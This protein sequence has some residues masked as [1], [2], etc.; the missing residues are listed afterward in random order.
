M[1]ICAGE[2][3]VDLFIADA[4]ETSSVPCFA[5][6]GGSPFNC[7]RAMARLGADVGFLGQLSQDAFGQLLATTLKNDGVTLLNERLVQNPTA[8]AVISTDASGHPAYTFHRTET[9]DR[10]LNYTHLV[11]ALPELVSGFQFGSLAL[12]QNSDAKTWSQLALHLKERGVFVGVDVNVRLA[13]TDDL[14][15]LLDRLSTVAAMADLLKCSDEDLSLLYPNMSPED[16]LFALQDEHHIS[17]VVMTRG[18]HG[19]IAKTLAHEAILVGAPRLNDVVDTVGAGDTFQAALMVWLSERLEQPVLQ[20][21]D[22]SADQIRE[23]L[24]FAHTAAALNCQ[25]K[26]CDPPTNEAVQLRLKSI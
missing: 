11:D 9:A 16:A 3:L 14:E 6:P 5:Q 25:R 12:A 13:L 15:C 22:L 26:G 19:A 2:S 17:L 21:P 8:L 24:S 23:L 1:L 18:A 10:V 4:F 7:A 20:T